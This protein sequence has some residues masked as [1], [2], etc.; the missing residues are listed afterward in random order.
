[1]AVAFLAD[2]NVP[3][4][5]AVTSLGR[6]GYDVAWM[7]TDGPRTPDRLVLERA[8][9]ENRVLLTFDKNFG[10]L[11]FLHR[12]PASSAV[13]L[14]RALPAGGPLSVGRMVDTLASRDA[15]R[16]H[17]SVIDADS[18]RMTPLPA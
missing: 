8:Q 18:L 2:V 5:A 15:W 3:G 1:V 4:L 7:L 11:A 13:I 9:R 17:F 6:R 10:E 14:I 16:G 12:L